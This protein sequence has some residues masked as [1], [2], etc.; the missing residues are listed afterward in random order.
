MTRQSGD[1]FARRLLDDLG[2]TE[3]VRSRSEAAIGEG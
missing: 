1:A 3:S 2:V